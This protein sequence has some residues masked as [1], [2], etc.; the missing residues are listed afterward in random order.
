MVAKKADALVLVTDKMP[1]RQQRVSRRAAMSGR[2][3][4]KLWLPS[5]NACESR[6]IAYVHKVDAKTRFTGGKTI[7]VAKGGSDF[8]GIM[9]DGSLRRVHAEC[10][11]S[12]DAEID[13]RTKPRSGLTAEQRE[14]LESTHQRGH[15]AIVLLVWFYTPIPTMVAMPYGLT[16]HGTAVFRYNQRECQEHRVD[17]GEA[18]LSRWYRR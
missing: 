8:R 12:C 6:G 18:Y 1:S 5:H 11:S 3:A 17:F 13:L 14:D 16:D 4:E 15:V 7:F 10:K 9:L 2:D